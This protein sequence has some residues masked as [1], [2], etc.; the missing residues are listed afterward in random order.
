MI[1]QIWSRKHGQVLLRP[2]VFFFPMWFPRFCLFY[3]TTVLMTV[4]RPKMTLLF[5]FWVFWLY[6]R[7]YISNVISISHE[8]KRTKLG[9][10]WQILCIYKLKSKTFLT[11]IVWWMRRCDNSDIRNVDSKTIWR[12]LCVVSKHFFFPFLLKRH[13]T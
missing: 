2:D 5:T 1:I 8:I 10:L 6:Y 4:P 11:K 7:K 3:M 12:C 9:C 13:W